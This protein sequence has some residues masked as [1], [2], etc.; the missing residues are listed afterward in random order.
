MFTISRFYDF[1][2][3]TFTGSPVHR[4]TGS[5][6]GGPTL[7]S[8][9]EICMYLTGLGVK[10]ISPGNHG[11]EIAFDDFQVAV[12]NAWHSSSATVD[13][14]LRYM[15]NPAG[16][17]VR[18]KIGRCLLHMGDTGIHSDMALTQ[19]LYAPEVGIVPIGDRFTMGARQAALARRKFFKFKTIVP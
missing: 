15:G 18:T 10:N 14:R 1:T 9:F 2:P 6:Y 17:V 16:F 4:F 8:N 12:V 5:R 13:G 19:E 11:G 3:C 7:V